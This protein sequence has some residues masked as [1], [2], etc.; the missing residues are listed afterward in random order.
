MIK[1]Q[2]HISFLR[3]SLSNP[4]LS[5]YFFVQTPVRWLWVCASKVLICVWFFVFW[6]TFWSWV[7]CLD[8][9]I[10]MGLCMWGLCMFCVF[11]FGAMDEANEISEL[12]VRKWV[13]WSWYE[14]WE[15]ARACFRLS[16]IM[17][18]SFFISDNEFLCWLVSLLWR[19]V[20]VFFGKFLWK[21]KE[22]VCLDYAYFVEN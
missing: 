1:E 13:W 11:R 14:L 15:E 12:S 19:W 7:W 8:L 5:L 20:W 3:S 6:L 2:L 4:N 18:L 22:S 16:L 17:S 10:L 9:W 21:W